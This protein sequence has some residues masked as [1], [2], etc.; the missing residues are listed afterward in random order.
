MNKLITTIFLTLSTFS[1]LHADIHDFKY[2]PND[3]GNSSATYSNV[4]TY[5]DSNGYDYWT[6]TVAGRY[7]QNLTSNWT[8]SSYVYVF[9]E[10]TKTYL[11]NQS[12]IY[13]TSTNTNLSF[14]SGSGHAPDVVRS[15]VVDGKLIS[16]YR[17]YTAPNLV[18]NTG[19]FE[20]N[21][22]S[23]TGATGARI[24]AVIPSNSG[25]APTP[26]SQATLY[27]YLDNL[28]SSP[29]TGTQL[30]CIT[31]LDPQNGTTTNNPVTFNLQI[32]IDPSDVGFLFSVN[33]TLHNIDLNTFGGQ[34]FSDDD[35]YFLDGFTATT[36][37]YFNYSTTTTLT[38]GNYAIDSQIKRSYLNGYLL[39]PFSGV[40]QELTHYFVV[41]SSTFIGR[42]QTQTSEQL[43][44]AL[45]QTASTTATSTSA[46]ANAC[47]LWSD[48]STVITCV[49]FLFLPSY[50][51][52]KATMLTFKDNVLIHFPMGYVTDF[53]TIISTTTQT[54]M[55]IIDAY[56]PSALGLGTPHI[57]LN[58]NNSLD[59]VLNSTTSE[60][61]NVSATDTR[62]LFEITN[63]YWVII[64]NL[65]VIF[66]ILRRIIGAGLLPLPLEERESVSV[67]V[68]ENI[69][70]GKTTA[71]RTHRHNK[72]I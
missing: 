5:T 52:I 57:V 20:M 18:I 12:Y 49:G 1:I 51:D 9:V 63:E 38:N 30:T 60:F 25:T 17:Y 70:T 27:D 53:Y 56:L 13:G 62:T 34:F 36:S 54:D 32:Y 24:Y 44:N 23:T 69:A 68:T 28:N 31:L 64:V 66:Y 59:W 6:R 11:Y 72:K 42:L 7:V 71:F 47:S 67:S 10:D 39:N 45:N 4:S 15:F 21:I 43:S 65:S 16:L 41:G 22:A 40:S 29:C 14:Y 2:T 37:G 46:M 8:T 3:T 48:D 33:L 26:N 55:V 58:L 61:N 19:M 35:I 50:T